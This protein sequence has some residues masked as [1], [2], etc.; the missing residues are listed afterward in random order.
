MSNPYEF[1][2]REYDRWYDKN[3]PA[4]LSELECIK[5]SIPSAG[6]GLEIGVGTGR[7]AAPLGIEWGID[8]IREMLLQVREH[9]VRVIQG[10]GSILPFNPESFDYVV[11]VT[12]LCFLSF[13][14][15]II[16]EA[17]R[18]LKDDGRLIVGFVDRESYLGKIYQAKKSK[19]RF[20]RDAKF[21]SVR[22]VL[23][24]FPSFNWGDIEIRQT[25]FE[26]VGETDAVQSSRE[27]W[28]EG[29]F[30]VVLGRKITKR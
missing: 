4:Y 8:P 18:V 16:E 30:V 22:E 2:P 10:D 13:P 29:G 23:Q 27:G 26:S 15:Q 11:M 5:E 24:L 12:V 20:Y 14:K 21:Y 7:F 19:S 6:V 25:L 1:Y 17:H 28:G 3:R 9:G